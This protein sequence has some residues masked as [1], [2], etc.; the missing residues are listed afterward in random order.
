VVLWTEHEKL[1]LQ[2]KTSWGVITVNEWKGAQVDSRERQIGMGK[3]DS[4]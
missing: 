2:S 3:Q 4:L 1:R